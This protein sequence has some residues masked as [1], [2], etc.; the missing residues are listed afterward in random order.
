M[1]KNHKTNLKRRD[2]I[3]GA[4]LGCGLTSILAIKRNK[5]SATNTLAARLELKSF[6]FETV[7]VNEFGEIIDTKT[8]QA[9]EFIE[10]LDKSIQMEMVAI[11][12]GSFTMGT[13][14][15]EEG[16][17][18][19]DS[20]EPQHEVH[21]K[22]FYM[23]RYLITQEQ[24]LTV[25]GKFTVDPKYKNGRLPIAWVDWID[26]QDFCQALSKI[27]GKKYRLPSEAEW[28]YVCRA[29]TT[30]PFHYGETITTNLANYNG[31]YDAYGQG[32]K[33]ENRG[34]ATEVGQFPANPWGLHDMH[35]N[36]LEWC[37]DVWFNSYY[38]APSDGSARSLIGWKLGRN[39][40]KVVRGGSWIT[41]PHSARSAYRSE[42]RF[43]RRL[44]R[45]GFRVACSLS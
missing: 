26:A 17:W 44:S 33:G 40:Y 32:P 34:K 13:S 37:E 27:T 7:K 29:G 43:Y 39:P 23:S 42:Y 14:E 8:R 2:L 10:D 25:M 30:T 45:I 19:G 9:K 28:E 31:N 16:I 20:S 24:W 36:L 41:G 22:P 15:N 38:G 4:L 5:I 11:A 18:S 3:F 21:I 35:G 1:F 12:G 6:N